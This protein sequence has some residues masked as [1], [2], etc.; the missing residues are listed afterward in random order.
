MMLS[1]KYLYFTVQLQMGHVNT[2]PKLKNV[3]N[4]SVKEEQIFFS[5]IFLLV[6][7]LKGRNI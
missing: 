1:Q 3:N 4:F 2:L 7:E 5:I 6:W